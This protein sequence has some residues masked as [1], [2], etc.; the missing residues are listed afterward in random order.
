MLYIQH[1]SVIS[2][3]PSNIVI[4]IDGAA[5]RLMDAP[6]CSVFHHCTEK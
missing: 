2:N 5:V 6:W 4:A 1:A 3:M